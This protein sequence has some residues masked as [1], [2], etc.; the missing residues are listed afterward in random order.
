[1][2]LLTVF[3]VFAKVNTNFGIFDKFYDFV[4]RRKFG[5]RGGEVL[6]D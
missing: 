6:G 4:I 5:I 2:E 3:R 1:M